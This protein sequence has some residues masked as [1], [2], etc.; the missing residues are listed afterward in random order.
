MADS[1]GTMRSTASV[2]ERIVEAK[3]DTSDFEK[4]VDKTIK[5]LDELKESLNLKDAGKSIGQVAEETKKATE[6]AS[7]SLDQLEKRLTTFTGILKQQFLTGIADQI[8]G[9]F[10]KM[11]HAITGFAKN[12]TVGMADAGRAAYEQMLTS[13]RMI[14]NA[15]KRDKDGK[16]IGHYE[17]DEAYDALEKL[18]SY[19]DETSYSMD[20]M[21]DAMSKMVAAGVPLEDAAKNVQGIANACA[22]AGVNATDASRAFFNLS[23]AYSSGSLK[24]TDYRSLELL[25]MTNEAFKQSML[26]AGVAAG[27]LKKIKDGQYQT[28]KAAGSKI[29]AGKKVNMQNLSESLKYG[30]MN[31]KGMDQLFGNKFYADINEITDMLY[32]QGMSMKEVLP[33]I[34]QKYGETAANAFKAAREARSFTDV[35]NT[36]KGIASAGWSNIWEN[37]FGKL[38]EA[39][40]FFTDLADGG[41]ANA[42]RDLFT[43]TN[44]LLDAWANGG[45]AEGGRDA[46]KETLLTVDELVGQVNS[47][48]M[49]L[50]PDSEDAGYALKR[51]TQETRDNVKQFQTWLTEA[52]E[53][54]ESRL[55]KLVNVARIFS[56]AFGVVF[57]ALGQAFKVAEPVLS[58][59]FTILDKLIEPL[60]QLGKNSK[61]FD[62]VTDSIT[63][64]S[65]V[66]QPLTNFLGEVLS[67]AGDV[68]A[69]FFSG[70]I[71]TAIMNITFFSDAFGLLLEVIT[72]NSAQKDRDDLGVIG[73]IT[74]DIETLKN[75][76]IQAID[77]VKKFFSALFAD[78]RK[79]LGISQETTEENEEGGF[80]SNVINFFDTNQF[81]KDAE[82]WVQQAKTDVENWIAKVPENITN[83]ATRIQQAVFGLFYTKKTKTVNTTDGTEKFEF[84]E[85]T[86]FKKSLDEWW[87][88]TKKTVTDFIV[89]IPGRM[90]GFANQIYEA[91]YSIFYDKQTVSVNTA[92]GTKNYELVHETEFKK[93]LDAWWESTKES[94]KQFIASIPGKI[95]EFFN[96]IPNLWKTVSDFLFGKEVD[97]NTTK[98]K[99]TEDGWQ[100][101]KK[102][103]VKWRMESGLSQWLASVRENI[104]NFIKSIPSRLAD[105]GKKIYA[106]VYG[107]FYQE[108]DADKSGFGVKED[109][110]VAT[111]FK[112]WIDGIGKSIEKWLKKL[113]KI[114]LKDLWNRIFINE[115]KDDKGNVVQEKTG[116]AVFLEGIFG[117]EQIRKAKENIDG[118]V[119]KISGFIENVKTTINNVWDR[120]SKGITTGEF[121]ET[122]KGVF[123]DI[124]NFI[125]SL[126]TGTT[127]VEANAEWFSTTVANAIT[128]IKTKAEEAWPKVKDF[129]AD[130][131]NKIAGIFKGES[132]KGKSESA[133]GQALESFGK[134]VGGFIADLPSTLV[135]F[136][137][138]AVNG[139][140]TLWQQI[141][142]ALSGESQ[143]TSESSFFWNR[144]P[145][146]IG[147]E[148]KTVS[149]WETFIKNLGTGISNAFAKFPTW[150]SQGL[151]LAI[152]G[153]NWVLQKLTSIITPEAIAEEVSDGTKG[154]NVAEVVA[155]AVAA[156]TDPKKTKES[157]ALA[158]SLGK[159]GQSLID[160]ITKTIP[161]FIV[162]GFEAVKAKAG[163]WW[164][165]LAD[166][167]KWNEGSETGEQKSV[168]DK[169]ADVAG[170]IQKKIE[171]VIPDSVKQAF[172]NMKK[173]VSDWWNQLGTVFQAWAN[174]EQ[175]KNTLKAKIG[176]IGL[177]IKGFIEKIPEDIRKAIASIGKMFEKAP[178][179]NMKPTFSWIHGFDIVDQR[180]LPKSEKSIYDQ[181]VE[182]IDGLMKKI[183]EYAKGAFGIILPFIIDGW[184]GMVSTIGSVLSKLGDLISGKTKIEDIITEVFGKDAGANIMTSLTNFKNTIVGFFKV[185]IPNAFEEI[186]KSI[187]ESGG[188]G[189][190]FSTL[191]GGSSGSSDDVG[192]SFDKTASKLDVI[193]ENARKKMNKAYENFEKQQE[194]LYK[195]SP[196]TKKNNWFEDLMSAI[197]SGRMANDLLTGGGIILG[198][199]ALVKLFETIKEFFSVFNV[200]GNLADKA[201][202]KNSI[203]AVFKRITEVMMIAMAF[204]AYA[205][206]LDDKQYEKAEKIMDKTMAFLQDMTYTFA[207]MSSIRGGVDLIGM[208]AP[209]N[210]GGGSGSTSGTGGFKKNFFSSLGSMLGGLAE[211]AGTMLK[212]AGWVTT[213]SFAAETV[214]YTIKDIIDSIVSTVESIAEGLR[215]VSSLISEAMDIMVEI[216]G[217]SEQAGKAVDSVMEIINKFVKLNN[218]E[219]IAGMSYANSAITE[220]SGTL[221]LIKQAYSGE[222]IH[223]E[224]ITKALIDIIDMQDK[225][226]EFAA[227]STTVDYDTFKYAIASLGTAVSMFNG[228]T[229][230]DIGNADQNGIDSAIKVLKQIFGS[231]ELAGLTSTL[232]PENLPDQGLTLQAA[233]RLSMLSTALLLI[234]NASE[235]MNVDVGKNVNE[236]FKAINE[237][238]IVDESVGELASQVG[239]GKSVDKVTNISFKLGELGNALGSFATNVSGLDADKIKNANEAISIF[240]RLSSTLNSIDKG[241]IEKWFT[242]SGDMNQFSTNIGIL[243]KELRNFFENLDHNDAGEAVTHNIQNVKA[244]SDL[245]VGIGHALRLMGGADPKKALTGIKDSIVDF[246]TNI[247]AFLVNLQ[248]STFRADD[249]TKIDAAIE[250]TRRI[251]LIAQNLKN[252][253]D[254]NKITEFSSALLTSF[255]GNIENLSFSLYSYMTNNEVDTDKLVHMFNGLAEIISAIYDV[256]TAYSEHVRLV[257][258]VKSQDVIRR[259]IGY[260]VVFS[261]HYEEIQKS[262]GTFKQQPIDYGA[263]TNI[264]SLINVL[265]MII[266]MVMTIHQNAY[267]SN[268]AYYIDTAITKFAEIDFSGVDLLARNAEKHMH[269][270]EIAKTVFEALKELSQAVYYF[271]FD[272]EERAT[273]TDVASRWT[274][275]LM[276]I[277]NIDWS[278]LG[279]I[280]TKIGEYITSEDQQAEYVSIGKQV[281]YYIARGIQEA[282]D[283]PEENGVSIKVTPVLDMEKIQTQMTNELGLNELT[284]SGASL[285]IPQELYDAIKIPDYTDEL[286]Q[287][288]QD[289]GS[290]SK[291][292]GSLG[293]AMANMKLYLDGQK[294]VG[295]LMPGIMQE[296]RNND[297][298]NDKG[299]V[300]QYVEIV[301]V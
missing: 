74:N 147:N 10:F 66:L 242:G 234:G 1:S 57:Y 116:F 279:S 195:N 266:E 65:R 106:T 144:D 299:L 108:Q 28:I 275:G 216:D 31:T 112:K 255:L 115:K 52:G 93:N 54:G 33:I 37:M 169:I 280:S 40:A 278:V 111:P 294:M 260:L 267:V 208:F 206:Q 151:E 21:T 27:T 222:D 78:L 168:L 295:G 15:F 71:D 120:I 272:G 39:T 129:I 84:L 301:D 12:M 268:A 92:S 153:V 196:L 19:A 210:S 133:I 205:S 13:V 127:D 45:A 217:K 237:I 62:D 135:A 60:S 248:D 126:F 42:I 138:N 226:K 265:D 51:F 197:T 198:I 89:S 200:A 107:I 125:A 282:F 119:D 46:F 270:I 250:V 187:E 148:T 79:I 179:D 18:K 245:L 117:E 224:E 53:D 124:V 6:K 22:N 150:I 110:M 87:E 91:V 199:L 249:M 43:W 239:D 262:V 70:A 157:S 211:S 2:D 176:A 90:K 244:V 300:N 240:T 182:F 100:V 254:V 241:P 202:S 231:E 183:G 152:K 7:D 58:G 140:D 121:K 83:F 189:G 109:K 243:G 32:K 96:S 99:N 29:T 174:D 98:M 170:A 118:F 225:M 30:W 136:F 134:T 80:F 38:E 233:E 291:D 81:L 257:D 67:I 285:T 59:A 259:G 253:G 103:T 232:T 276:A 271:S 47:A 26:D 16:I 281:A 123:D 190:L 296:M 68:A 251:S 97:V 20:Q 194:E 49:T 181:V 204:S 213:G 95:Q 290:L 286:N 172:E 246:G 273:K 201:A 238:E 235:G 219:T 69:F 236:L 289:I 64:L 177:T 102:E 164:G 193:W 105:L 154:T 128:W 298:Y 104:L 173:S 88:N 264:R 48:F 155:D 292:I 162:A 94:I 41:V 14:T 229:L 8:V 180:E 156:D 209:D 297:F 122:I 277:E 175:G 82:A 247:T 23:Q 171:D 158:V 141:Y 178:T 143:E 223:A 274:R 34:A 258:S 230:N 167:F 9:V 159:I 163:E 221:G 256:T 44:N 188:I 191:F 220:L 263:L 86:D 146:V 284:F 161:A 283:N 184:N 149:K 185:T 4:G 75:T 77:A 5:K 132:S 139:I 72:G 160:L 227:F 63:N 85:E 269:S 288:H 55:D 252:V 50:L 192:K 35:L 218:E 76:C 113:P 130:I 17:M 137:T 261:N 203:E 3:F 73:H 142:D 114:T 145:D 214:T 101:D 24:Y 25:N 293:V 207:F 166:A 165:K 11:E 212:T 56:Q 36:M 61:P 287:I 215:L 228:K 186:R 131:P